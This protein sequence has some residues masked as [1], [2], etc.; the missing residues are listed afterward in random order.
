[1][2]AD[3]K[4]HEAKRLRGAFEDDADLHE[5]DQFFGSFS[6]YERHAFFLKDGAHGYVESGYPAGLDFAEDGRATAPIDVDGDGDLD[7]VILS[8]QGLKLLYNTTAEEGRNWLRVRLKATKTE[9]LA[10]G[11]VVAVTAGGKTRVDRVRITAGFHSQVS[12]DVHFGLGSAATADRV[13]I[14]WPSGHRDVVENVSG[15]VAVTEGGATEKLTPPRWPK[16]ALP[17]VMARLPRDLLARRIG[18]RKAPLLSADGRPTVVN[19]WAPWC[20]A[21]ARELPV[22]AAF[23]TRHQAQARV[24]GVSVEIKNL[25]SVKRFNTRFGIEYP[26]FLADDAVIETF[27]GAEGKMT[28]PATFVFSG[29]GA[30]RRVFRREIAEADLRLAVD[31]GNM[32]A[33]DHLDLAT[34]AANGGDFRQVR[35]HLDQA[36]R[37]D[38][39]NVTAWWRLGKVEA[40]ERHFIGALTAFVRAHELAPENESALIDLGRTYVQLGDAPKGIELLEKAAASG[41]NARALFEL[42]RAYANVGRAQEAAKLRARAAALDPGRY[43]GRQ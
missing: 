32:S 3:A 8:L 30:L 40:R 14:R 20:K 4:A 26:G 34:E 27:F 5:S 36:L 37:I 2:V 6:G 12:T 18:G 38:P 39:K 33:E 19:F 13:E 25:A 42:G 22:L 23:A 11:A 28:L 1:M 9:P 35:T 43:G 16:E 29:E 17:R 15:L 21:C 7:L 41:T 10:L 31:Q 24:V